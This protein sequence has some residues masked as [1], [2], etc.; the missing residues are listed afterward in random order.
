[1]AGIGKDFA[2]GGSGLTP[3][4]SG[5]PSLA[6]VLRDI[7]TD[8]Q[9]LKPGATIAPITAP[10]LAAFTDP[11]TAAEMALLRT[12][13]NEMR[14]RISGNGTAGAGQLLTYPK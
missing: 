7:A 9:S 10:A 11:P 1:M 3:G 5:E 12:L 6:T 2:S 14:T 4:S 13:V 8:L